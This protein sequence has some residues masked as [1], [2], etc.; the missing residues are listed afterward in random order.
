MLAARAGK[1]SF[2]THQ[3]LLTL[4]R[5]NLPG[6]ELYGDSGTPAP[7]DHEV[8]LL[9]LPRLF[10]TRHETIP[11][12]VPYLR[13]PAKAA[14]NWRARLAALPGRKVGLVWAGR[15]EH[16]ND[17]RR[18]LDLATLALLGTVPGV[19]FVSL[20]VGPH[21]GDVAR[22][23]TFKITD[24][25]SQLTDFA[26]TAG[27]VDALD[28][29]VTVD[30]AVA[31]LVGALGKPTWVLLPEVTDWRWLIG[32]EDNPWYPTMRLY[33]RQP[34]EG[35]DK[36]IPRVAADLASVAKGD[37]ARLTPF[38]AAGEPRAAIAAEVIAAEASHVAAATKADN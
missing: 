34:G 12:Q 31:H 19:S 4:M 11:A 14:A 8:A 23:P 16:T 18:S 38:R 37:N 32:R 1:V 10:K 2:R 33:R 15:P 22:H 20:Q 9:S 5:E 6:I 25:S 21:A 17:H 28:L 26:E 30:T 27:A 24:L 7:A 35:W 3:P 36:V 29:V 13:A